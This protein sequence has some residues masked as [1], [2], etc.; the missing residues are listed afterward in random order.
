MK[1]FI[2]LFL[3][4]FCVGMFAGAALIQANVLGTIVLTA[5]FIFGAWVFSK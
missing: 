5:G 3:Y 2:N 4:H 1:A